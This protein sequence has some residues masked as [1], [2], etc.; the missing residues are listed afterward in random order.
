MPGLQVA[1]AVATRGTQPDIARADGR[2]Q[3]H[4][5]I[6]HHQRKATDQH[7]AVKLLGLNQLECCRHLDSSRL[8]S[9]ILF[10]Q[11]PICCP[12]AEAK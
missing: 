3:R 7:I 6:D 5:V 11:R 8:G 2:R 9:L 1:T 10:L 12:S 4:V